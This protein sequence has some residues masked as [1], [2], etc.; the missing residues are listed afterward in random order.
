[1]GSG[2]CRSTLDMP[3]SIPQRSTERL[4]GKSTGGGMRGYGK[5]ERSVVEVLRPARGGF[6][7]SFGC[8]WFIN[9]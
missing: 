1:M 6:L 7:R 3:A 4:L 5:K 8:G 2:F 9:D